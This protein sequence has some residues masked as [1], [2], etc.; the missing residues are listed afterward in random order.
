MST[1]NINNIIDNADIH[2]LRNL[3]KE[4][5]DSITEF[6][7]LAERILC[8]PLEDVDFSRKLSQAVENQTTAFFSRHAIREATDWSNVYLNYIKPWSENADNLSI[9]K[10][11]ELIEVI[12]TEVAMK[13]REEDFY[14]DD[15]YDDDFSADIDSIMATLENLIC[16][17]LI[18]EDIKDKMLE[19]LRKLIMSAQKVDVIDNYIGTPYDSILDFIDIR[20]KEGKVTVGLFDAFIEEELGDNA[21]EWV[22]REIDFLR[23]K[24]NSEEAEKIM[25]DDADYPE[26]SLKHYT[27][28]MEGGDWKGAMTILDKAQDMKDSGEMRHSYLNPQWLDLKQAILLEHGSPEERIENL[29]VLFLKNIDKA[30]YYHQLKELV[31]PN[32]WTA[33]Y[34]NLLG[35][36]NGY[37][38]LYEIAPFLIEENEYDWL[39]R[40]V[41]ETEKNNPTDYRTPLKYAEALRTTHADQLKVQLSRTIKAYAA[42]RYAPKKKVNS[43]K[44]DYFRNDIDSIGGKGYPQL[45]KELVGYLLKEYAFRPALAKQLRSIKL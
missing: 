3:I 13:V 15:W 14:G 1:Q 10:L 17:L 23:A 29:K 16:L 35:K 21:G 7:T 42:D 12:V 31:D 32:D 18:R 5:I 40:L 4:G 38:L 6:K 22:C 8:P 26:V 19:S 9:E 27:E 28:L 30:G 25:E 33:F 39:Y 34:R 20:M 43:S 24:G 37:G 44:Y 2:D 45:R 36:M 11:Y 41:A